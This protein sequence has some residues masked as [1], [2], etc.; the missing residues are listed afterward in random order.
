MKKAVLPLLSMM[1]ALTGCNNAS[2]E[3]KD[4]DVSAEFRPR[5]EK[6]LAGWSTLDTK[7]VAGYYAK[8]AGLTFFDVAPLKYSGWADYAKGFGQGAAMWKSIKITLGDLQATRTGNIVW[9]AYT[10]PSE[11]EPKEGALMKAITRNTDVFEKRGDD[12]MIVHEHVSI[13]FEPPPP[14]PPTP[15]KKR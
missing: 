6:L 1:F 9:A 5:I 11:I 10:A 4:E 8:D 15:A 2:P 3:M 12:W 7:N 14:P 13:P